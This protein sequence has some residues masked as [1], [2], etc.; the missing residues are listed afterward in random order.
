MHGPEPH[1]AL[2]CSYCE[3]PASSLQPALTWAHQA[4][5]LQT[6]SRERYKS[7]S[8]NPVVSPFLSL[9]TRNVTG[10]LTDH[11]GATGQGSLCPLEEVIHGGHP[12]V[13]H[14]EVSVDIDAS[15]D[16]HLPVGLNGLHSSRDNQ[17][18]SNLP[19]KTVKHLGI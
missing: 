18:V 6:V 19:G 8:A 3:P 17:I 15:G 11:G 12:L 4:A 9:G 16:H 13:G 1:A 10:A 14:L 7:L 2:L 5:G